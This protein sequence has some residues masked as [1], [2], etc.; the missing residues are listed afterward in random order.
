MRTA[1]EGSPDDESSGSDNV[2]PRKTLTALFDVEWY[3]LMLGVFGH[4]FVFILLVDGTRKMKLM[5]SR[6]GRARPPLHALA[7]R[8][9]IDG[10]L[11]ALQCEAFYFLLLL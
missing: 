10:V 5:S 8:P 1:R 11:W 2:P 4:L 6:I 7:F 3:R 9:S